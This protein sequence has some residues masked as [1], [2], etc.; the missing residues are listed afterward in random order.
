MLLTPS[1]YATC[2]NKIKEGGINN[3]I[4]IASVLL[5]PQVERSI[6][7]REWCACVEDSVDE[8]E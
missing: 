5:P 2:H 7:P 1:G 4:L 6:G 3:Q 8:R